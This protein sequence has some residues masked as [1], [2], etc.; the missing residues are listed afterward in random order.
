MLVSGRVI[1]LFSDILKY[2][3]NSQDPGCITPVTNQLKEGLDGATKLNW[4]K[5]EM[6]STVR[7][8][9]QKTT[10]KK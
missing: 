2:F 3:I 5:I 9:I 8:E 4:Y 1:P 10:T 7:I 6:P